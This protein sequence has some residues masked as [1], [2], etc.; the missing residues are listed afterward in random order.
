MN[1]NA[2]SSTASQTSTYRGSVV[3]RRRIRA[4]P[5]SV[6]WLSLVA[7][8]FGK[9]KHELRP[10]GTVDQNRTVELARELL[11]SRSPS[12]VWFSSVMPSGHSCTIVCNDYG[13]GLSI[14]GTQ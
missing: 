3:H 10:L 9:R 13:Q 2:P 11:T 1:R 6:A 4:E 14:F 12:D 7:R 8:W 5:V